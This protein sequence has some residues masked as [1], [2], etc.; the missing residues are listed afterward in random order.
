MG[1]GHGGRDGSAAWP[2]LT[3][4]ERQVLHDVGRRLTNGEI[5]AARGI[6]K[7]TVES[8]VS[9]LLV[10]FDVRSR[11]ELV[12]AA[13]VAAGAPGGARRP[14]TAWA[15]VSSGAV[16]TDTPLVGRE[17]ELDQL[18]ACTTGARDGRGSAV[19]V[20]GEPGIGKSRLVREALADAAARGL[21]CLVGHCRGRLR[22]PPATPVVEVLTA[23]V[24]SLA[25]LPP[26]QRGEVLGDDAERLALLEPLLRQASAGGTSAPATGA[27]AGV[28]PRGGP[29]PAPGAPPELS[30]RLLVG[31]VTGFLER[32]ARTSPL[33]VVVEDVHSA[34]AFTLAVLEGL[35]EATTRCPLVVLA[36]HRDADA[37]LWPDLAPALAR[38]GRRSPLQPL[39]LRPLDEEAVGHL[40]TV[41][42][43]RRPSAS[44]R[45]QLHRRT[46]GNPFFLEEV[47][48]LLGTGATSPDGDLHRLESEAAQISVP[49]SVQRAVGDRVERLRPLA[50][51]VLRVAALAGDTVDAALLERA[52]A[53]P[54]GAAGGQGAREV[55]DALDEA[56]AA[57]LLT[58][59]PTPPGALAFRH[60]LVREV[61]AEQ[62]DPFQLRRTRL[63]LASA[64]LT[65]PAGVHGR[66]A[67]DVAADLV[68]AG[69]AAAAATTLDWCL[70]AGRWCLDRCDAGTA[71]V[72]LEHAEALEHAATAHQLAELHE[73]LATARC[74]T[75]RVDA[76]VTSWRRAVDCAEALGDLEA[77]ARLCLSLGAGLTYAARL[78]DAGP[79]LERGLAALEGTASP[80]RAPLMARLGLV[81]SYGAHPATGDALLRRAVDLVDP[82][83]RGA[84]G[85]VLGDLAGAA[86]GSFRVVEA[87]DAG[88][89]GAAAG[90]E[91]GDPLTAV[92]ALW[93]AAWNL[94][95]LGLHEE[96][97]AASAVLEPLARRLDHPGALACAQRARGIRELHRSGDV[98]AYT[99]FARS[100]VAFVS[101]RLGGAWLGTANSFLA[102]AS[103]LGGDWDAADAL[104]SQGPLGCG[105]ALAGFC[106][107]MELVVHGHRRRRH[108]VLR[109]L[110]DHHDE[111]PVPGRTSAGGSWAMALAAV[112][113]LVLVGEHA[114]AGE[115]YPVVLEAQRTSGALA[116]HFAPLQ[117]LDRVC[118]TAAAAAGS[119]DTA[120]EH[121]QRALRDAA[122]APFAV[123]LHE[124][125]RAQALG[126]LRRAAEGDLRRAHGLARSA[127]QGYAALGMPQHLSL[128][129]D[130]V[131]RA[132]GAD[133][134]ARPRGPC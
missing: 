35:W 46:G 49:P 45:Q 118:G 52:L 79:L 62:L 57:G 129:L 44:V 12:R 33:V 104:V 51:E 92:D 72:H 56:R 14:E 50:R 40:V 90:L 60:A 96:S 30:Q 84:L 1:D 4:R 21:T 36:T 10:K 98:A 58:T 27:A 132:G 75:G 34:D 81:R 123:E 89:R 133:P 121:F 88:Q 106:T 127:A 125:Q 83:D 109:V 122:G 31:A 71:L 63:R 68:A 117:L 64:R 82:T 94:P 16:A 99:A 124:T 128:A 85:S 115:L 105:P 93:V 15:R 8:H 110:R 95:S 78:S 43:G 107:A 61:L 69:G 134:P 39:L 48:A 126:L 24:P 17:P 23:A 66:D 5:A 120:E 22:A 41:L 130:L 26:H 97:A 13:A 54:A 6:S 131:D 86:H 3:T 38:A 32:L 18:L 55:A 112:E 28:A 77:V 59:T 70:R 42:T 65:D 53:P 9:S 29:T 11:L 102:H 2:R 111:L 101:D 116:G 103:L 67:V 37:D 74:S 113:A 80:H 100:D 76:A 47:V 91:A 73:S 25:A 108:A 114:A 119:W 7:R 20:S 19:L 87:A